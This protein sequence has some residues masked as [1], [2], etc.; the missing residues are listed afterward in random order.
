MEP[1]FMD[2]SGP[3]PAELGIEAKTAKLEK[4]NYAR[5]LLEQG[6]IASGINPAPDIFKLDVDLDFEKAKTFLTSLPPDAAQDAA[7]EI[8]PANHL[9]ERSKTAYRKS[10]KAF[11]DYG[12]IPAKFAAE[13]GKIVKPARIQTPNLD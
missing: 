13:V 4:P 9:L 12:I 8:L 11:V 2:E 7:E 6:I 5:L 3:D 1:P 10:V